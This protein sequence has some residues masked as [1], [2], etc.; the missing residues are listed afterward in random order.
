MKTDSNRTVKIF[1]PLTL[2][3]KLDP[4][5]PGTPRQR[6]A[7]TPIT[8]T[9]RAT[10]RKNI[11]LKPEDCVK[12]Q[13]KPI[14]KSALAIQQLFTPRTRKSILSPT[15]DLNDILTCDIS[16]YELGK[17]LGQGASAV[18][19][20]ATHLKTNTQFAIKSYIKEKLK[21][22]HKRKNLRREIQIMKILNH[23]NIVKMHS[24]LKSTKQVHI[25]QDYFKGFSLNYYLK[26]RVGKRLPET[27][28][29]FVFK[30]IVSAVVYMHAN[31]IAHRDIKL[32]N[33][34]VDQD[35]NIKLIDFGFS[36]IDEIKSKVFCGTPSYMA[37]EI[38]L[39]KEYLI[40]PTDVWALGVV[41]YGLLCGSF[42]FRG[43]GDKDLFKKICEG[44]KEIPDL[45]P[46]EAKRLILRM[47]SCSPGK[48]PSA[49]EVLD[50]EWLG[51]F[52]E[53][54]VE[55]CDKLCR[56]PSIGA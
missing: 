21:E 7:F 4:Q 28:A 25:V 9:Y 16:S 31:N 47:L 22:P 12:P 43:I 49:K 15:S 18:V 51:D 53:K 5:T 34:L 29:K 10:S 48:R 13:L 52:D 38:V 35:L 33:I 2:K 37:P 42:P 1:T 56:S 19:R 45:V 20:L 3:S 39:R 44:V 55:L 41:L 17:I 27:E 32:E 23:P 6:A 24:A 26:G 14:K 40:Y 11:F 30:Q 50:N 46:A 54:D 36:S 8:N